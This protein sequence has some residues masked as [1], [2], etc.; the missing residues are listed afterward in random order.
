[1]SDEIAKI[2]DAVTREV[3]DAER[4][5]KPARVVVAARDYD[6]DLADLWDALTNSERL[7]RW[8][9]KVTGDFKLGGRYAIEGNAS[10]TIT[11]CEPPREV[12]LTWEFGPATSWVEV[13]LR[14]A[15]E[16]SHLELR[17]IAL[18]D[19]HWENF[20]PGATGVGWDL[21]LMGLSRHLE[22]PAAQKPPEADTTW[23]A[24]PEAKQF[25][26]LSSADWGR[27]DIASGADAA[28]ARAAAE[29]TRKFYSGEA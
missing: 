15:G 26:A 18:I 16:G 4:E 23:F 12:A 27:A 14:A 24:S 17:H 7:P 21:G 19:P 8:F 1:M 10:G 22:N 2:V 13:S 25:I 6:T 28:K 20:G 11:R 3:H 29:A 9:A 5:G